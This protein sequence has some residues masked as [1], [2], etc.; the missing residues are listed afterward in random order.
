[1]DGTTAGREGSF[2][3]GFLR[4]LGWGLASGLALLFCLYLNAERAALLF[5]FVPVSVLALTAAARVQSHRSYWLGMACGTA[6][7]VPVIA[8]MTVV[9][10]VSM[11]ATAG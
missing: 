8:L 1:M 3:R 5:F 4:A 9:L 7:S 11:G 10:A 2:T 6:T